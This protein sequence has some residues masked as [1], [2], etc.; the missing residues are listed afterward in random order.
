[1]S[2]IDIKVIIATE[3]NRC[4]HHFR[5]VLLITILLPVSVLDVEVIIDECYWCLVHYQQVLLISRS[6]LASVIDVN[7]IVSKCYWCLGESRLIFLIDEL[8]Y[9]DWWLDTCDWITWFLRLMNL[10]WYL[11]L[12]NV[13]LKIDGLEFD[14]F[15]WWSWY[16]MV[17]T[18]VIWWNAI[19]GLC[20]WN[21]VKCYCE[22][23]GW[24][25]FYASYSCGGQL[26]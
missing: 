7:V 1:M 5:R 18:L 24:V 13:I 23:L 11:R 3:C 19:V 16:L 17:L 2:V 25:N 14:V 26:G 4:Q 10:T 15:D 12:N 21:L 8:N 22:L 6:L 9:C 20:L